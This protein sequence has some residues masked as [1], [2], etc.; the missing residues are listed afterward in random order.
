[1]ESAHF[2]TVDAA[3][4]Q[5]AGHAGACGRIDVI[6]TVRNAEPYT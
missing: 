5:D 2:D 3:N 6:A 1:M 4:E